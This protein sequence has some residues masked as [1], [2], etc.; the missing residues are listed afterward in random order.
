[1]SWIELI[2]NNNYEIC[3]EYPH[4]IRKKS[5]G[6]IINEWIHHSGYVHCS[7]NGKT[8]QK[9]RIIAIQFIPNPNNLPFIDHINTIKT[10]NRIANLRFCTHSTNMRNMSSYHNVEAIYVDELPENSIQILNHNDY[11]FNDYY[12][13]DEANIYRFNGA[14]YYK[15]TVYSHNRVHMRDIT[16]K[17]HTFSVN[18]L[19]KAFL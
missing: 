19:I 13:D 3:V 9:H 14:R 18:G 12:I 17:L 7:L 2:V 8:Y 16:N 6:R 5:N 15:L 1:M 4:Q 11:I 10:D